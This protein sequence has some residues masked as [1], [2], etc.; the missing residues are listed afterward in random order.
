MTYPDYDHVAIDRSAVMFLYCGGDH[1]LVKFKTREE[2]H[3]YFL[4]AS[5]D[6]KNTA[7]ERAWA[8]ILEYYSGHTPELQAEIAE[9]KDATPD[10]KARDLFR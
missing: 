8:I 6:V 3:R 5:D 10:E 7:R 4:D 1:D 2:A 9:P